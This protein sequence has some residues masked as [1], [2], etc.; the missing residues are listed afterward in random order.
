V[1]DRILRTTLKNFSTFFLVA[2]MVALPLF[3]AHAFWFR[4]VIATQEIHDSIAGLAEGERVRGVGPEDL[5]AARIAFGAV[6]LAVL[7]ALPALLG[8]SARVLEAD[9]AGEVPTAL[10]AWRKIGRTPN[11]DGRAP[12]PVLAGCIGFAA[13]VWWL[14]LRI[15]LLLAEPLGGSLAWVGVGLARGLALALGLPWILVALAVGGAAPST[16]ARLPEP[17]S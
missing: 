6:W 8:A 3:L 7:A 9:R 12:V 2:A 16:D 1:L 5:D 13:L 14:A 10:G 15:G 4:D 17:G 11:R